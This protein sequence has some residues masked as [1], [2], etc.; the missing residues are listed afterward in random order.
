[1]TRER[2]GAEFF[3]AHPL[4]ELR[5][6]HDHDLEKAGRLTEPMRYDPASDRYRPVAWA[7]AFAE[8]GAHLRANDPKTSVF[9]ASGHAGLEAS[10]LYALFARAFGHQNLPQS[11]NMCHETTSVNLKRVLGPGAEPPA[12][13]PLSADRA[14]IAMGAVVI[15]LEAGASADRIAS[16][17]R[18][19]TAGA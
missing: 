19:L 4:A 15:R 11:S 8:I 14:E 1:M 2:V 7:D 18:A 17:A 9:Y 3:D 16:V 6:W 12:A 10:Y 5:G 13:V